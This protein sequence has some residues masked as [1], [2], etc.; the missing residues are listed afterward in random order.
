[1]VVGQLR[2][3]VPV[4]PAAGLD[5]RLC[6]VRLREGGRGKEGVGEVGE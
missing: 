6:L 5:Q 4:A 2:V 3:A 1:M